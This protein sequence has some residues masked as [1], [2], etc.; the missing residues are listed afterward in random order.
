M[1]TGTIILGTIIW[2]YALSVLHRA[3]LD[4]IH[5]WVGSVGLFIILAF[6]CLAP[7]CTSDRSDRLVGALNRDLYEFV[8][9]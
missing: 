8:P 4:A 7:I 2:L 9:S 5:F 1:I 3:H 6:V